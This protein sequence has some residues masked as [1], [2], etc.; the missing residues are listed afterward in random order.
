M[1]EL[2]RSEPAPGGCVCVPI[3][4][5]GSTS[6]RHGT[7]YRPTLTTQNATPGRC[8]TLIQHYFALQS[9]KGS[10]LAILLVAT[11][12]P[13]P[14]SNFP[15]ASWILEIRSRN[16]TMAWPVLVAKSR[17]AHQVGYGLEGVL[18]VSDYQSHHPPGNRAAVP[19]R[20]LLPR[21][22]RRQRAHHQ[23]I[24]GEVLP[25]PAAANAR[26][27]S[28]NLPWPLLILGLYSPAAVS[29]AD[30]LPVTCAGCHPRCRCAGVVRS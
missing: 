16:P 5:L 13:R 24:D 22:Q 14:S 29:C 23:L 27:K 3:S 4:C 20:Q 9:R 8:A 28:G 10:Q 26:G 12:Q 17:A 18:N 21:H 15:F 6:A 30:V 7:T 1:L 11:T 2:K 25:E 19:C